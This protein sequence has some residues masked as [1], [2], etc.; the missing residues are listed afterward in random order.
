MVTEIREKIINEMTPYIEKNITFKK[1]D[2]ISEQYCKNETYILLKG[3][4]KL[5]YILPNGVEITLGYYTHKNIILT[6]NTKNNSF[7]SL[8]KVEAVDD[9]LIGVVPIRCIE[10][11][12]EL[13]KTIITYYDIVFRKV[14]LQM[15]DLL[16]RNKLESFYSIL[17]RLANTYGVSVPN[18][19]KIN[20]QLTNL[21]LASYIGTAPETISRLIKK[22]KQL[23]LIEVE[24]KFITL[25]NISYMKETLGCCHCFEEICVV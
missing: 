5:S 14:Y 7:T 9:C 16:S 11:N 6:A 23:N 2:I 1:K 10:N 22:M 3:K 24:N 4:I 15:V 18:G 25:T 19:I 21:D 12:N 8:F 20:I 13:S 17:I